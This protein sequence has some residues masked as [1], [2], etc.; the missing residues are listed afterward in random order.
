MKRVVLIAALVLA[1]VS[2]Q[3][4][5]AEFSLAEPFCDGMVLPKGKELKVFGSGEGLVKVELNGEVA[6]CRAKEGKWC[7]ELPAMQ[8]GGPYVLTVRGKGAEVQISDIYIGTVLMMAGQSN[9]QFK[10]RESVTPCEEWKGDA[11][12]REFSLRRI[13]KGEP[14]TPEDGWVQCTELNAGGFSAIGYLAGSELR[15][16]TGEAVGLVNCY[17]GASVIEAWM[18]AEVME[19]PEYQLPKEMMHGDHFNRVYAAWNGNGVLYNLNIVP[20]APYPMSAVVWYQGESNT[21][22]GE[23]KIYPSLFSEMAAAW[24]CAFQDEELPFVIVEIAD[25]A[26]RGE[27]WSNFQKAQETIPSIVEKTVAVRSADVCDSL[28]IHPADKTALSL[29][30]VDAF[31][32]L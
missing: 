31:E 1:A 5:A 24:R 32:A 2:C 6:K 21:G 25:M 9:I 27:K 10:L 26:G 16:R 29:R 14:Y 3:K 20:F 17:Q 28:N 12:L 8:A 13:E 30:I 4:N 22:P 11:L 15:R 18:P 23:Y 19:N 7:A